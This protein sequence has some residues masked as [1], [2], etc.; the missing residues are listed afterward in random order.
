MRSIYMA[1]LEELNNKMIRLGMLCETSLATGGAG[2]DPF[3]YGELA[4]RSSRDAP[5]SIA[6]SARSKF[7][8]PSAPDPAAGRKAIFV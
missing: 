2:I 8:R 6:R 3:R 5:R 4:V 1:E 7:L